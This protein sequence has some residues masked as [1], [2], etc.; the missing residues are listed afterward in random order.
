MGAAV[1]AASDSPETLLAS[2][3]PN[4]QLDRTSLQLD[5]ANFL[6]ISPFTSTEYKVH[7]NGADEGL[8]VR[9]VG[10]TQQQTRLSYARVA[11][12]QKLEQV[13]AIFN[14]TATSRTIPDSSQPT[15]VNERVNRAKLIYAL[16]GRCVLIGGRGPMGK[17]K[18]FQKT[19][20]GWTSRLAL[21]PDSG[22]D[23]EMELHGYGV[24]RSPLLVGRRSK[25]ARRLHP[26]KEQ[27]TILGLL[28]AQLVL[29]TACYQFR[30][31]RLILF[32]FAILSTIFHEFGHALMCWLTGARM[33]SININFDESGATRFSGGW[34]CLI[35]PAGYI[36][37][38]LIGALL[39]FMAFGHRTA[40]W[41]AVIVILILLVTLFFSSGLFTILSSLGL[42][43]LLGFAFMFKDGAFTRH[44]ILFLG[45]IASVQSI[46][47]ILNAT[48]FNTIEGSDAYVFAHRCSV[49][50]PA[51]VYGILW[52]IISLA[53][54][55]LSVLSALVVFKK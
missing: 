6:H 18:D 5:C 28:A 50:I 54:L 14:T 13:I 37:S 17:W 46:L 20:S 26:T 36:G 16:L 34:L 3:V 15:V 45:A 52:F 39:V 40:K 12:Q 53:L 31:T 22:K 27:W 24:A 29:I 41:S 19:L 32:P 2:R 25:W 35:L 23:D 47:S 49:L 42:T 44:V 51:F 4:L 1:I 38:T 55:A 21:L 33:G 11:N 48:V 30:V 9:V 8:G 43:A 10:K 7:S